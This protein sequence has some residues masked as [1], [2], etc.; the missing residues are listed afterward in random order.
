MPD[1]C[2]RTRTWSPVGSGVSTSC[3]SSV[4]GSPGRVMTTARMKHAP[5][6]KYWVRTFIGAF[7]IIQQK[8][9]GKPPNTSVSRVC[10]SLP[11]IQFDGQGDPRGPY[12]CSVFGGASQGVGTRPPPLI[13]T[14]P[15]PYTWEKPTCVNPRGHPGHLSQTLPLSVS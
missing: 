6:T 9:I 13:H 12:T 3:T 1:A 7:P 14:S 2:T 15:C 8:H 5:L 10:E 4:S 11:G